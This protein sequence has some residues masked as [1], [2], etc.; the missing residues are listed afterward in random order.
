MWTLDPR[1]GGWISKASDSG[2]K[3]P[4][5]ENAGW[6]W[7]QTNFSFIFSYG[8]LL[9]EKF[10]Y[11]GVRGEIPWLT[12][13]PWLRQANPL[14]SLQVGY[15]GRITTDNP[16]SRDRLCDQSVSQLA[17]SLR[18]PSGDP[19]SLR[20]GDYLLP[21][22]GEKNDTYWHLAFY[23]GTCRGSQTLPTK[24][25]RW[26]LGSAPSLRREKFQRNSSAVEG[27][28]YTKK[29]SAL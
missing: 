16:S 2:S 11:R 9:T 15:W 28:V 23:I 1:S 6:L 25:S 19:F 13:R 20:G 4:E 29:I 22:K 10:F 12:I 24:F 27:S 17:V 26:I 7:H 18:T 14:E 3:D 5:F 8:C 21:R